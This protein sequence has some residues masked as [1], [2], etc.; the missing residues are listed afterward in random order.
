MIS[1]CNS[2]SSASAVTASAASASAASAS[3]VTAPA[4]STSVGPV[5]FIATLRRFQELFKTER[6][7]Q[8]TL[9]KA[10]LP[11]L[12]LTAGSILAD[13]LPSDSDHAP[14]AHRKQA[15]AQAL[16][17]GGFEELALVLRELIDAGHLDAD[18]AYFTLDDRVNAYTAQ[19]SPPTDAD[20]A[21]MPGYFPN[22]RFQIESVDK[23]TE[24]PRKVFPVDLCVAIRFLVHRLMDRIFR[25]TDSSKC[26]PTK[27]VLKIDQKAIKPTPQGYIDFLEL[28]LRLGDLVNSWD[29]DLTEMFETPLKNAAAEANVIREA[30]EKELAEKAARQKADELRSSRR[31]QTQK[32]STVSIFKPT[33][34][35]A[36]VIQATPST[37]PVAQAT[38]PRSAWSTRLVVSE[39]T[40][41]T[42]DEIADDIRNMIGVPAK[43]TVPASAPA[44]APESV[45][46]SAPVEE[47]KTQR[48]RRNK[49]KRS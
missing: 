21:A 23:R 19:R 16:L 1:S 25:T 41:K 43:K 17:D 45:P 11:K 34:P 12:L 29:E 48:S 39:T 10:S 18:Y 14:S 40:L 42:N 35:T 36:P 24:R 20:R 9:G 33:P 13:L 8:G 49:G 3:A 28:L 26:D 6:I 2:S 46:A 38:P 5:S 27:V 37:A 32:G 4:A 31:P 44:S 30:Y 7:G 47:F 15:S 22:V